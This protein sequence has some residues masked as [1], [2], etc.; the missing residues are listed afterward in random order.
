MDSSFKN[1]H[2]AAASDD[3]FRPV[4]GSENNFVD[5]PYGVI[6]R[7]LSLSVILPK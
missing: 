7:E 5:V 4:P 6:Q 3:A 1:L 2:F